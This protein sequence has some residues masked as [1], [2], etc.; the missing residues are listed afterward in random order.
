M[1]ILVMDWLLA[2]Q[3]KKKR[4]EKRWTKMLFQKNM[5]FI[6]GKI[7][8][9]FCSLKPPNTVPLFQMIWKNYRL[10]WPTR[11]ANKRKSQENA[12]RKIRKVTQRRKGKGT[13][14]RL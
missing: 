11:H 4:K 10:P 5:L 14:E 6:K 3:S 8:L 12:K 7:N 1:G 13:V 9:I 2:I